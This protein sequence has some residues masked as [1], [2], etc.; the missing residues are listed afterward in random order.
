MRIVALLLFAAAAGCG[1]PTRHS[2]EEVEAA[3]KSFCEACADAIE[4]GGDV[5]TAKADLEVARAAGDARDIRAAVILLETAKSF[6]KLAKTVRRVSENDLLDMG[7]EPADV[8][9]GRPSPEVDPIRELQAAEAQRDEAIAASEVGGAK[10]SAAADLAYTVADLD[11]AKAA[12]DAFM[13][14]SRA[15][16]KAAMQRLHEF[17]DRSTPAAIEASRAFRDAVELQRQAW[18]S[19]ECRELRYKVERIENA[20]RGQ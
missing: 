6:E 15:D 17:D 16:A 13:A 12:V 1:G 2:A 7:I 4:A 3:K 14:S 5:V 8:V 19:V 11:A 18:E 10:S 20:L 9:C